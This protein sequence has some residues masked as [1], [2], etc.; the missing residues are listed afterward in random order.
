[1]LH[2][3]YSTKMKIDERG[4]KAGSHA[5]KNTVSRRSLEEGIRQAYRTGQGRRM[6]AHIIQA[7]AT[8]EY[9]YRQPQGKPV[10]IRVTPQQLGD[11]IR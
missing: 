9:E 3:T 8:V 10:T 11:I 1:M 5:S 2:Y 7:G 4:K 6:A